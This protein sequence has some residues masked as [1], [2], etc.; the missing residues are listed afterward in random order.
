MDNGV[1]KDVQFLEVNYVRN[2]IR[3]ITLA[4]VAVLGLHIASAE[5][6]TV[7]IIKQTDESHGIFAASEGLIPWG[8]GQISF[9]IS[10][11]SSGITASVSYYSKN[12]RTAEEVL[13]WNIMLNNDE[14]AKFK[15]EQWFV[16]PDGGQCNYTNPQ[17]FEYD[18]DVRSVTLIPDIAGSMLSNDFPDIVG[19]MDSA[20]DIKT[21]TKCEVN[22]EEKAISCAKKVY[23]LQAISLGVDANQLE[24]TARL[25]EEGGWYDV[26]AWDPVAWDPQSPPYEV[27]QFNI[28]T[29]G[30]T[31]AVKDYWFQ[32]LMESGKRIEIS[33]LVL[34]KEEQTSLAEELM[35]FIQTVSPTDAQIIAR[36]DLSIIADISING[37][38]HHIACFKFFDGEESYVGDIWTDLDD[39]HRIVQME[40]T[41]TALG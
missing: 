40:L 36:W 35:S 18:Q 1:I 30:E 8:H 6:M 28:K 38:I 22:S 15:C 33:N 14:K 5:Q 29:N 23:A 4:V 11:E 34:L 10:E 31:G 2:I 21:G 25:G 12:G 32:E 39:Q 3:I 17:S 26:T 24:W 19:Q 7:S 27:K 41:S 9:D 37:S 20:S 16:S 13:C